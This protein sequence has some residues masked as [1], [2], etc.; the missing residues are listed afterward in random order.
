MPRINEE[1]LKQCVQKLIAQMGRLQCY[2]VTNL[3]PHTESKERPKEEADRSRSAGHRSISK[4]THMW[5]LS[6]GATKKVYLLIC[7]QESQVCTDILLGST[8]T[9][10]LDGLNNTWLSKWFPLGE[11]WAEYKW[12]GQGRGRGCRASHCP[13]SACESI[14]GH[15]LSI[16]SSNK[17]S[18]FLRSQN[19][20][21]ALK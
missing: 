11:C 16:T 13:G 12:Q 7:P 5:G 9:F 2:W 21:V 10:S 6:W 1:A 18:S 17:N 4:I 15:V 3:P 14:D 19:L 20:F 8:H